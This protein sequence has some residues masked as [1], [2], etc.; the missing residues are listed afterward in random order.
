MKVLR[1]L[2]TA[3]LLV[4]M[5]V[6]LLAG[7]NGGGSTPANTNSSKAAETS[8]AAESSTATTDA[9][10]GTDEFTDTTK[11]S[12]LAGKYPIEGDLTFTYWV[13]MSSNALN[14][15]NS[16]AE[17]IAYQKR[18]EMT[19]VTIDFWHPPVGSES[20]NFNLMITGGQYSDIIEQV[21]YF[22]D[23]EDAGIKKG[24]FLKMNDLV[25]QFA[26]AYSE[27]IRMN[28]DVRKESVTDEGNFRGF[29]M[30]SSDSTANGGTDLTPCIENPWTGVQWNT[31]YLEAC[32]IAEA[33]DSI[34]E[35]EAAFAAFKDMDP[36]CT[37][38]LIWGNN[39][40]NQGYA[41]TDGA[42]ITAFG[43]APGWYQDNGEVK[44][45][46]WD[47]RYK[48]Y[49]ALIKSWFDKGYIHQ[50]FSSMDGT[51]AK[52]I[53]LAGKAGCF[54]QDGTGDALVLKN[55][56][57]KTWTGARTPSLEEGGEAPKWGYKNYW[58]R[59]FFTLVTTKCAHPE[60]ATRWLDWGY[61]QDGYETMNFGRTDGPV[62][63][64]GAAIQ[65]PTYTGFNE[66]GEAL[67]APL[68]SDNN[69]AMWDAYNSVIRMHN[70]CYLKSDRRSNPRRFSGINKDLEAM[71]IIWEAQ[72]E[73]YTQ[74]LPNITLTADEGS[75]SASIMADIEAFVKE[76]SVG[77]ING[78]KDLEKD[79]PTYMSTI[80]GMNIARAIEIRQNALAR[81]NAR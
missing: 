65:T 59:G 24:I 41:S 68:Y 40:G 12:D 66:E 35:W 2:V 80:E 67:Y 3:L 5:V 55:N 14:Y 58:I 76:W 13:P 7:C 38:L 30:I 50:D 79:F 78:T 81:Y 62:S 57:F 64:E 52:T 69:Y 15:I 48:D 37:P 16:Y 63:P 73:E 6:G 43:I 39:S 17:N 44:Y 9:N 61:T 4:S 23:G 26:P 77:F 31:E 49:L 45:G 25:A 51:T 60:E 71:R 47:E 72:A 75:E 27:I 18:A 1:K 8:K 54:W 32:N 33:P 56:G 36:E 21:N 29:G 10:K 28:E 46:F 42:V 20:E 19:G 34:P 53:W 74:L 11:Q 70:G 22:A